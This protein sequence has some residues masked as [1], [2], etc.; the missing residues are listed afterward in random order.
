MNAALA[1]PP[2]VRRVP[3]N[4]I[5][6]DDQKNNLRQIW[7]DAAWTRNEIAKAVKHSR[8]ACSRMADELGLGPRPPIKGRPLSEWRTYDRRAILERDWPTGRAARDIKAEMETLSGGPVPGTVNIGEWASW[9]GL[10][11]PQR[12]VKAPTARKEARHTGKRVSNVVLLERKCL[13][14]STPFGAATR[15]LRLCT[16]CR[17]A[18]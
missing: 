14:C 5:W 9:L 4:G 11:R 16:R 18:A 12:A 13:S 2:V 10:R 1:P 7:T 15:F 17:A 3:P 6:T 8:A